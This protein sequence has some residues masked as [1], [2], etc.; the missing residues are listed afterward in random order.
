MFS[1][2]RAVPLAALGAGPDRL[3]LKPVQA[4]LPPGRF[5]IADTAIK[6]IPEICR[7]NLFDANA[8]FHLFQFCNSFCGYQLS[9]F[10]CSQKM[11]AGRK[12]FKVI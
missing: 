4:I 2:S 7:I 5:Y 6:I 10:M 1:S 3:C 11:Y 12:F 8:P 9:A